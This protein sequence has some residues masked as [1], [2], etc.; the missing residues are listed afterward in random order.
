MTKL[1]DGTMELPIS[2]SEKFRR[3]G[4]VSIAEVAGRA[5]GGGNELITGADMRFGLIGKT[6]INQMEVPLGIIPGGDGTVN[7]PNLIGRG[8]FTNNLLLVISRSFLS[9]FACDCRA[10]DGGHPRRR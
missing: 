7:L 6:K 8:E 3:M 1:A 9:E 2:N 5:G 4:K 10:C